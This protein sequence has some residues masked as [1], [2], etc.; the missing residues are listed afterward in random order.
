MQLA[1]MVTLLPEVGQVVA[2]AG[3]KGSSDPMDRIAK[4][5]L[6]KKRCF[7]RRRR[8]GSCGTVMRKFPRISVRPR[9]NERQRIRIVGVRRHRGRDRRLHVQAEESVLGGA[10]DRPDGLGRGGEAADGVR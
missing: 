5:M 3:S 9:R 2:W 1:A 7:A 10:G 6:K 4:R 8:F